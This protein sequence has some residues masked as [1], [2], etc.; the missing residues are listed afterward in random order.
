[1]KKHIVK[2]I[3][4]GTVAI[5]CGLANHSLAQTNAPL[6]SK[7]LDQAKASG[8]AQ[9]PVIATELTGKLQ[10][11]GASLGAN[12]VLKAKVDDVLKNFTGGKDSAALISAL[13]LATAAKFTPEQ[14]GLAKQVG[15]LASAYTVQKNFASLEG[16][17]SDVTTIVSS[18]RKGE[19]TTMVPA[20]QK[21]GKN[22]AL[23][24]GQKEL[25]GTL[26]DNYAPGL[27]KAANTLRNVN[28]PGR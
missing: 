7:L 4:L 28:I 20:L 17:Q 19:L 8:D 3:A 24:P 18:L 5:V 25:F 16:S 11:F 21:V 23:S 13:K 22:A 6:A 12:P 27:R 14:S 26:M 10:S 9:L 2:I 1:M 15:N